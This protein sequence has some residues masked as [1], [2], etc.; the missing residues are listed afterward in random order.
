MTGGTTVTVVIPALNARHTITSALASVAAQTRPPD[1]VIVVDDGSSDGTGE[2]ARTWQDRLP[3]TVLR[4]PEKK[5]PAAARRLAIERSS[6][7]SIALLDA[8][9]AWLPDHLDTMTGAQSSARSLV[10]AR[11]IRWIPG[12]GLAIGADIAL[13]PPARQL[14]ELLVRNYV[15]SPLFSREMYDRA[16]PFRDF[17]GTED[18]D[19]WIRMVRCGASVIRTSH[20]TV[21][22]RL[23]TTSLSADDRILPAELAVATTAMAEATSDGERRA[24]ARSFRRLQARQHLVS[25]YTAAR[26]GDRWK[27]RRHALGALSGAAPVAARGLFLLASPATGVRLR[28]SRRFT[29][30]QWLRS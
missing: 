9:D 21:L 19:L 13:P 22:Y 12:E 8:D 10:S 24:A 17:H 26:Q 20:P 5:G 18:W 23:S 29:L 28:D 6:T 11:T 30:G 4:H 7:S 15:F 3:L 27:A 14:A 2:V 16:G 25:S 1:E